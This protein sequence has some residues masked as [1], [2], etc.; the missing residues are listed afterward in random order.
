MTLPHMVTVWW[1]IQSSATGRT[2]GGWGRGVALARS[3]PPLTKQ[4]LRQV[5]RWQPPG[6]DIHTTVIPTN[7]I[8]PPATHSSAYAR[9]R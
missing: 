6:A 9:I 3:V 4:D 8:L 7:R 1:F 2:D 5:H